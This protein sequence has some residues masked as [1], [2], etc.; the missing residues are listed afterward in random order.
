MAT[1]Y[2][3]VNMYPGSPALDTIVN[4]DGI[5]KTGKGFNGS[6]R[7]KASEIEYLKETYF[8][9]KLIEKDYEILTIRAQSIL[10]Y[11][12]SSGG[13]KSRSGASYIAVNC[14]EGYGIHSVKRLSDGEVFTIGDNITFYRPDQ[15]GKNYNCKITNFYE[16]DKQMNITTNGLCENIKNILHIKKP[17]FTTEDGVYI[18]E[19]D[20]FY[21]PTGDLNYIYKEKTPIKTIHD[22]KSYDNLLKYCLVVS[23]HKFSTKE[24]AEKYILL[25][26]PCL[27][28]NE[29]L[30]IFGRCNQ[31]AF[32]KELRNLAKLKI[33]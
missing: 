1:L 10:H 28:L 17:L 24:A 14:L 32:K 21:Y 3:L 5:I 20:E 30:N 7:L 26:K 8:W 4:K 12:Q 19:G 9:E 11:K 22:S 23:N 18:F 27:S 31:I 15:G 29:V 33:I 13:F 16:V 2:K 25:N 6:R